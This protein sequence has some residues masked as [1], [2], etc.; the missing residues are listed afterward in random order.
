MMITSGCFDADFL[1]VDAAAKTAKMTATDVIRMTIRTI[2][3]RR[4]RLVNTTVTTRSSSGSGSS[5]NNGG[6]GSSEEPEADE[7]YHRGADAA[8]KLHLHS[9]H[10][11]IHGCLCVSNQNNRNCIFLPLYGIYYSRS[12]EEIL[13]LISIMIFT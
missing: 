1:V 9:Y 5:S 4:R 3:R 7:H 8:G 13:L 6:G 12:L 11:V 2:L 10:N